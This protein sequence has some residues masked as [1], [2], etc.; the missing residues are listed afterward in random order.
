LSDF[1][2]LTGPIKSRKFLVLDIESKDDD[3]DKAGFTRPFMVGVYGGHNYVPFFDRNR[4][5]GDWQSRYY[6][7]G[8]CID[9]AMRRILA[10]RYCGMHI[11]AHNAG[12]F[13]YLF[14][15]P[16]LMTIGAELG[17]R[18]TV[19]P[20]SSSIQILDVWKDGRR[21]RF[22]D[23]Y[24]LIPTS[25][26]KAAKTFGVG[27]KYQLDLDLP[28]SSPLW[29]ERNQADCVQ[30]YDI[31]VK[32][33]HYIEKVLVS[34]V[35]ITTPSTSI[36]LLRRN[37]L[38]KPLP[39]SEDTHTFVR[40]GYFGGRVEVFK[41]EGHGLHYFDINSSYPRAML[42][43]M[44]G[45]EATEWD[46]KPPR[47]VTSKKIGF[48]E[49]D[50]WVPDTINIPPLPIRLES[51]KH[52][53]DIRNGAPDSKLIFPAGKLHGVWEWDE[54]QLAMEQ[55]CR[56]HKWYH[57][58]WYEPVSIF[59]GFVEELYSYR[60]KRSP[61]YDVGLAE[62]AKLMLN[63]AYGK[64]GMRTL[65]KKI[66]RWDDPELPENAVPASGEPDS[67]IWYA[68]EEVDAP[69]IM[70][71]VAARVTS[72]ARIRLY[73][74]M[75][76]AERLGGTVYYCDTDSIITDVVLPTGPELGALKD[77]GVDWAKGLDADLVSRGFEPKGWE[78]L[79]GRLHGEF[80][81]PKLYMLDVND[82]DPNGRRWEKI[83]AKGLQDRSRK[84]V[85][86]LA[87]GGK[88]LQKRLE[89]VGSLAKAGFMRGPRMQVVPRHLLFEEGK[90]YMLKDGTTKPFTVRMW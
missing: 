90:R 82:V 35:G 75:R 77:E 61:K 23:S 16:W 39:R 48:V 70:P 67:P 32:F 49:A 6:N 12:R 58:T 89:K 64:F 74:A 73:R 33:H 68:E 65:R 66:Y 83:K 56:I 87:S 31:L 10:K 8:G 50:V 53:T 4:G 18:F 17:Y 55:G 21:W 9:L 59:K 42:E 51:G 29:I 46:G 19:I 52:N 20:V 81:G 86:I 7:E 22:L 28:E 57:S 15:L 41:R 3:T 79:S 1:T 54:L 85:E 60:D 84:T 88:V 63:S 47:R 78:T 25:L 14:I 69:Y 40:T 2:P 80:I 26:D 62:V 36:K 43:D 30:L 37:Y 5:E 72:L 71:Q 24:K 11:Y 44:P 38:A 34:E 13:D 45:G 76:E 27:T